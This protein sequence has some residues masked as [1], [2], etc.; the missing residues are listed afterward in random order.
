MKRYG[1][2]VLLMFFLGA[3]LGCGHGLPAYATDPKITHLTKHEQNLLIQLEASGIQV[4]K[5]GMIFT[6]FIPTDLF[7]AKDTR[8]LNPHCDQA[9]FKLAQFL[10]SYRRYLAMPHIFVDGFTSTVWL[11]PARKHLAQHYADSIAF[12]LRMG[13]VPREI[14]T[15][16]AFGAKH[17]IASNQYARA[18]IYNRRVTVVIR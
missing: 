5:Q 6:F 16:R 12:N 4:I 15:V 8:E 11:Y 17:K 18:A 9:I 1:I 13:G 14:M 7:F 10:N 3:L 2:I